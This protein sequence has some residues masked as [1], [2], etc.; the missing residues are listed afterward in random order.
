MAASVFL[1]SF[2]VLTSLLL[3]EGKTHRVAPGPAAGPL[4]L[5][6]ILEKSGQYTTLL[7]LLKETQV[8]VQI[9]SQLNNS[10]NGL[11]LFAPT[12]NAFS[13]LKAGTLNGLDNQDQVSLV[14]YHVLP[15]FY[16]PSMFE[17]SSNPVNTQASGSD[18]VYTLNVTGT[19]N[20]V[21]ISTGVDEAEISNILYSEFPLTIYSIDKVLLPYQLFGPKP[22]EAAPAPA[23]VVAHKKKHKKAAE[24]LAAAPAADADLKA[25]GTRLK[26]S[27]LQWGLALWGFLLCVGS[28]M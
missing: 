9:Q 2:L 19:S 15:R 4:N 23:P 18:G 11:T 7:R 6:T 14:L 8:G 13:S 22:P 28:L 10:Y 27:K 24:D 21:N 1:A 16:S 25:S 5:T 17:S 3:A 20:Q 26:K 12:D